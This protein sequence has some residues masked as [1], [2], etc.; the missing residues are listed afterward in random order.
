MPVQDIPKL[1]RV[2]HASVT[3]V[4][5]HEVQLNNGSTIPFEYLVLASGSTWTDPVCSGTEVYMNERKQAQAVSSRFA[6]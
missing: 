2:L 1:G 6:L 4:T 5:D 3:H